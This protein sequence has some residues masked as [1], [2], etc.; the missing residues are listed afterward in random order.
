MEVVGFQLPGQGWP[1]RA[2]VVEPHELVYK[3]L[4]FEEGEELY[5]E[6]HLVA[7]DQEVSIAVVGFA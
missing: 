3:H 6:T 5:L 4:T 1:L 2:Q 7:A